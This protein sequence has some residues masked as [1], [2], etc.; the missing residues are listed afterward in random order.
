MTYIRDPR[1]PRIWESDGNY[2]SKFMAKD[3]SLHNSSE[4]AIAHD[5][6]K[7]TAQLEQEKQK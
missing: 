7:Q 4:E 1:N 3:G 5:K 2:N 6:Q